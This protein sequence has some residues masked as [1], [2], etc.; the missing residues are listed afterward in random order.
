MPE[1]TRAARILSRA[2]D[3]WEE[4]PTE[5][6]PRLPSGVIP[7]GTRRSSVPPPPKKRALP[8][9]LPANLQSLDK[10]LKDAEADIVFVIEATSKRLDKVEARQRKMIGAMDAMAG[11]LEALEAWG[12]QLQQSLEGWGE[13]LAAHT[14]E[15]VDAVEAHVN[16]VDDRLHAIDARTS[17]R[18]EAISEQMQAVTPAQGLEQL[19]GQLDL[20]LAQMSQ[21]RADHE[22]LAEKLDDE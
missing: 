2:L 3:I 17:V 5:D 12:D 13:V 6:R 4:K 11:R 19:A 9:P 16:E 21:W 20:L 18:L 7:A 8:P 1:D 15:R 10:R 22:A 14:S